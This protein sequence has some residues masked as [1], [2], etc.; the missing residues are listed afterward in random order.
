MSEQRRLA[1][2]MFTDMVGYT[3]LMGADERKTLELVKRNQ[4]IHKKWM[5]RFN[6]HQLKEIGD[7]TMISFPS[8]SDAVRCAAAIQ[9]EAAQE[10]EL[11]LRIGIHLGEIVQN[12]KEIYGDGVNVANRIEAQAD[13][14]EI[15][16]SEAVYKNIRNKPGVHTQFVGARHLKNVQ[17]EVKIYR[18]SISDSDTLGGSEV[19]ADRGSHRWILLTLMVGVVC[20][21]LVLLW[22]FNRTPDASTGSSLDDHAIAVLPFVD[23]SAE[24]NQ[25]YL[26]D[27][28]AAEIISA[29]SNIQDL[30]V[31]GQ[32]SSFSFRDK[33]IDLQTIGK[34]LGAGRILE[35]SVNKSEERLRIRAQL[36]DAND[37]S[38]IWSDNYERELKDIFEIQ[39]EI[40]RMIADKLQLSID[41]SKSEAPPTQSF[42]AYELYLKG[43]HALEQGLAGV[44]EAQKFMKAALE[45]DQNFDEAYLSLSEIHWSISLYGL[46]DH[47]VNTKLAKESVLKALQVEPN[48]EEAYSF[49]GFLNLTNDFDWQAANDHFQKAVELGLELPDRNHLYYQ[50]VIHGP[51]NRQIEEAQL[52]VAKDPLSIKL[53]QDLSRMYLFNRAYPEVIRNGLHALE[54]SPENTSI[55]RHM[56]EAYLFSGDVAKAEEFYGKLLDHDPN[57]APHG[58]IAALVANE[59]RDSANQLFEEI[60]GDLAP[61]KR[62]FC[63]IYLQQ[64]DEAFYQLEL[65]L[66]EKDAHMAF[67]RVERH[68]DLIR[69]DPRY[70]D[71]VNRLE[72]PKVENILN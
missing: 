42:A 52:L 59:K 38:Q 49:L 23:L 41:L 7:G 32:T 51:S 39:D 11:S 25:T 35:G 14:G 16:I 69:E 28:I 50:V 43:R 4:K 10:V 40:S 12:G 56:A 24:Q 46:G 44:E 33:E 5:A 61:I 22:N 27:G 18:V 9:R 47:E 6:G 20:L 67:L 62:A 53:L 60:K 45:I 17:D 1:A 19:R 2:I 65:A 54:L 58:Y 30:K 64:L 3:T 70:H 66:K 34:Q 31:I 63:H 26:G 71:L 8:V 13:P 72:F 21:G 15:Y 29:I 48:N 55:T 57:Y 37:A 36:I 68:F